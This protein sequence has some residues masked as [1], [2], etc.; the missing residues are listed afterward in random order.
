MIPRL[1]DAMLL[2]RKERRAGF[3]ENTA[4]RHRRGGR[5][6]VSATSEPHT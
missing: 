5:N 4:R 2:W 1:E 3:I 6:E